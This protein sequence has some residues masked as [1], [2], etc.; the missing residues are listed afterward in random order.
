MLLDVALE[1]GMKKPKGIDPRQGSKNVP[2]GEATLVCAREADERCGK[3][4]IGGAIAAR[5]LEKT[6]RVERGEGAELIL[7]CA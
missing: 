5:H 4:P 3:V 7:V 2:A 6:T 1:D